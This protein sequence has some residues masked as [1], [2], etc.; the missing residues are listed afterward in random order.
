V[1]GTERLKVAFDPGVERLEVTLDR[2]QAAQ[3]H[4]E[5]E[6]LG[7]AQ[8]PLQRGLEGAVLAPH[9]PARQAGHLGAALS[10]HI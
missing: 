1:L 3:V 9:P 6:A 10:L 4:G 8:A 5:Q 2:L 7:L